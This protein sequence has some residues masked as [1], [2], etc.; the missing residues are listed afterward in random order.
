MK[1]YYFVGGPKDGYLNEFFERL[2][3]LGGSPPAWQIYPH[4]N[5]DG[6]ALHIV[7]AQSQNEIL[8]HLSSFD[9]IYERGEIIEILE[10]GEP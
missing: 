6:K 8:D 10:K 5:K 3:K 7:R 4:L 9:D 1:T 2:N